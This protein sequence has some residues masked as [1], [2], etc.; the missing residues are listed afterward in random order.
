MPEALHGDQPVSMNLEMWEFTTY[1]VLL[2]QQ[3]TI[4]PFLFASSL[5]NAPFALL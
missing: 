4:N 5:A 1:C 2:F 3:S